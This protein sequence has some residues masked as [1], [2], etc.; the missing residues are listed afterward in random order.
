VPLYYNETE[1]AT[2]EDEADFFSKLNVDEIP[3]VVW[4]LLTAICVQG[5]CIQNPSGRNVNKRL[6][7]KHLSEG[8]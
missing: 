7:L 3:K 2:E 4:D 8:R 5:P 1:A 6:Q